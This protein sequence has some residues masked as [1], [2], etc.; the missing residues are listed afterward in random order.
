MMEARFWTRHDAYM[1]IS[2]NDIDVGGK[3]S[4]TTQAKQR[5]LK[6]IAD[7]GAYEAIA[8]GLVSVLRDALGNRIRSIC[9]LSTGNGQVRRSG[10]SSSIDHASDSDEIPTHLVSAKDKLGDTESVANKLQSATGSDYI[11]IGITLNPDNCDRV[12]DRGP[13]ADQVK[14]VERFVDLWGKESAILRRFKD[15]AIVHAVLYEITPSTLEGAERYLSFQ[16]DSKWQGGIVE[17]IIR[18][19]L[20]RHFLKECKKTSS[21]HQFS[22]RN[23]ISTVDGITPPNNADEEKPSVLLTNPMAAHRGIM[24]AFD[25]LVSFLMRHSV[26]TNS[27]PGSTNINKSD[28][29]VPLAIDAVEPLSPALRY[30]ELFPPVPHPLLG[31]SPISGVKRISGAVPS[32]PIEIQLRFGA[33][34]KWPTD[35]KA[36]GAAKTAMLISLVNGIESMKQLGADCEG[37]SGPCVVTPFYADIG[38]MGYVFRIYVRADPELKLLRSLNKPTPEASALLQTLTRTTVVAASHHSM[39]H[40]VYTSHPSSSAVVRMA[41]RWM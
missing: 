37:F 29:G 23:M 7:A 3:N 24:N 20:K 34:S 17:R 31:A 28:L 10:S 5:W 18:H 19:I 13:P 22:L 27:T 41:R 15:G 25:S 32:N 9:L 33:S 4:N 1:R 40:A 39:T 11:V 35:L 16:N 2:L 12:V 21:S 38:F 30:V 6:D 14:A 26:P 8:R 36:I